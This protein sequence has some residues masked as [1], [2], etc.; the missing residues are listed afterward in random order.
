M[1][2][3]QRKNEIMGISWSCLSLF[4][5]RAYNLRT[6]EGP[7]CRDRRPGHRCHPAG[8]FH[9]SELWSL[10]ADSR[11]TARLGGCHLPGDTET[12]SRLSRCPYTNGT[13]K[14]VPVQ[15]V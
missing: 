3:P 7:R 4:I 2:M 6:Y 8:G 14:C 9:R 1:R 5:G 11:V 15:R 10:G 13:H 12:G